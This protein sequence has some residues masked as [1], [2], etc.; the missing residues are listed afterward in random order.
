MYGLGKSLATKAADILTIIYFMYFCRCLMRDLA[1]L[2][3][4][5]SSLMATAF[6]SPMRTE[7]VGDCHSTS[8]CIGVHV[9]TTNL[10]PNAAEFVSL[11]VNHLLNESIEKQF[12]AFYYGFH[13]VSDSNALTVSPLC[14][15]EWFPLIIN[16]KVKLILII[17]YMCLFHFAAVS[18]RGDRDAGVWMPWI[19]HARP[20][21][22]YSLWWV[23]SNW[24]NH[25]VQ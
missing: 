8:A 4:P 21:K 17:L 9:V 15:Q 7:N 13:S 10:Y 11:Y 20:R 22:C 16:L 1:Q 19:Q 2:W 6:R 18:P 12:T 14:L 25:Q 24:H 3:L 5:S 23:W